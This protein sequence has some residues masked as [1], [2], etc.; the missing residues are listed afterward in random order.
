MT[1]EIALS[2]IPFQ[3][4][5]AKLD[6][7]ADTTHLI[8]YGLNAQWNYDNQRHDLHIWN[9]AFGFEDTADSDYAGNKHRK[10][11]SEWLMTENG[12]EPNTLVLV[13]ALDFSGGYDLR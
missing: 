12:V 7:F 4:G 13:Q 10:A 8:A 1:T 6:V 2:T 5:R 9:T 11:L 3:G